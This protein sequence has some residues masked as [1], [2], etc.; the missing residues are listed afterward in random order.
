MLLLASPQVVRLEGGAPG[1]LGHEHGLARRHLGEYLDALERAPD[2]EAGPQVRGQ[3]VDDLPVEGDGP[4]DVM[5]Q[6][7]NEEPLSPA[8]LRRS[9][10]RTPRCTRR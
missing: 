6:L 8:Q 9:L 1:P 5:T 10:P 4:A 3:V 7:V 2:P